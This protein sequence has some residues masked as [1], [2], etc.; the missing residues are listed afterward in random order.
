MR[1]RGLDENG[2]WLFG[3]GKSSYKVSEIALAQNIKTRLLEWKTDCFFNNDAGVDWKNRLGKPNEIPLLKEEIKT[4][5][6][7]TEGVSE[8]LELNFSFA[9][10]KFS[11]SYIVKTVFSQ[12]PLSDDLSI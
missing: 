8:L 3:S 5:I 9:N 11:A 2:D 7:K 4:V 12:N 6:L 1:V 10:R